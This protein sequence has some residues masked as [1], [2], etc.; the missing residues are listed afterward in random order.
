MRTFVWVCALLVGAVAGLNTLS[1]G[2]GSQDLV[3]Q[4]P[5]AVSAAANGLK[6]AYVNS[7]RL[8]REAPGAAEARTTLD[9]EQNKY[10]AELELAQDSLENMVA[11][12]RQKEVMLSPDAKKKQ[13]DAIRAREAALQQRAQAAEQAMNKRQAD[14][15]QPLMDKINT[16]LN[17]VRVEGGYSLIL[18]AGGGVIISA[19]TTLDLT[20]QVLTK[21]KAGAPA[22]R[23]PGS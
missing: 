13:Q 21:L 22:P 2:S 5:P 11:D 15:I 6:I 16:V 3:A 10:R 17:Q 23:K 4:A 9:R 18:N 7:E 20:S 19:D 8:I 12:Y 1:K 14:L